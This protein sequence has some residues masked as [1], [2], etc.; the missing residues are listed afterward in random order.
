MKN[1]FRVFSVF[2]LFLI[3]LA[4]VL[5]GCGGNKH[6]SKSHDL[7]REKDLKGA[8]EEA[9][10]AVKQQ[11]K[12]AEA[13]SFLGKL[14]FEDKNFDEAADAYKREIEVV[15]TDIQAHFNIARVY[16]E[17]ASFDDAVTHFKK[18]IELNPKG[19]WAR[20]AEKLISECE[21]AK[22]SGAGSPGRNQQAAGNA[23]PGQPNAKGQP[24]DAK[25]SQ[26]QRGGQNSNRTV[27]F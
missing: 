16:K 26:P 17:K 2:F 27:D 6:L 12:N 9:K 5:A 23:K 18:V 10:L 11:P 8:I 22:N 15:P 4:L 19:K 1:N 13:L 20:E 25:P 14:H 3:S 21:S 24:G 7:Y